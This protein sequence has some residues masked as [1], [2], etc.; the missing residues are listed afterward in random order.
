VSDVKEQGPIHPVSRR[1]RF[2]EAASFPR[3]LTLLLAVVFLGLAGLDLVHHRHQ[4]FSWEGFIGFHAWFG[5]GAFC[6]VVLAGW[7][8]RRLLARPEDYYGKDDADA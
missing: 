2:L 5:F 6:V 8:L 7:P 4:L 3:R 1:L